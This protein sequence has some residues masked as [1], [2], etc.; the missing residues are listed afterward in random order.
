VRLPLLT[1]DGLAEDVTAADALLRSELG[2]DPRP[3]F[4][5]PFGAGATDT[6]VV[7]GL[8]ALGYRHV[9]WHVDPLDWDP[10]RTPDDVAAAVVDGAL[11]E[12]DGTVVLLHAWPDSTVQALPT[13]LDR[14]T[15]A[16]ARLVTV[17]EL[18]TELLEAVPPAG[19]GAP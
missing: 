17:A 1:D 7:A 4:R 16:G 14:L 9:G 11:A 8:A 10:A 2:S 6:R 5:C 19:P 3:W 18:P 13:I 15:T 12:G